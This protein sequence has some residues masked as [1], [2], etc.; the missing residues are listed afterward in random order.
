MTNL[1]NSEIRKKAREILGKSIFDNGWLY[2]VLI[3]LI[4]SAISG[5]SSIILVGPFI[6]FGILMC[7][8]SSYFLARVRGN[9]APEK[10]DAA[11]DGVKN[12]IGG[13]IITG[14]LHQIFISLWTMLFIIPGIVKGFSY[15]LTY[16]V[17][18]DNPEMSAN[19]AITESRRLMDGNKMRLFLLNLSFIGWIF[20][21]ALTFGI[22]TLWVSAYMET[23][24]AIFYED[25]KASKPRVES[26]IV[27]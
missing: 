18:C 23:S 16:Y 9:A 14:I 26:G 10:L 25:V 6:I 7:A 22:G 13:I 5:A 19:E 20:L 3:V 21:G 27:A 4:V 17:K 15:A 1:T 2:P 11:L 24:L 12:D 8:T